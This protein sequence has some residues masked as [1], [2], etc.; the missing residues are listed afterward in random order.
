MPE[1]N[2]PPEKQK[3][4]S[5]LQKEMEIKILSV[6]ERTVHDTLDFGEPNKFREL[7]EE[8]RAKYREIMDL[9]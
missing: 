8:Y 1:Q 4:I 2:I 5:E 7:Y 3:K 6:P 9:P